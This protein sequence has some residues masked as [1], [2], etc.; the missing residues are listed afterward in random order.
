M[1]L[2]NYAYY[3]RCYVPYVSVLPRHTVF[4]DI[5]DFLYNQ[6]MTPRLREEIPLLVTRPINQD[7]QIQQIRAVSEMRYIFVHQHASTQF[8]LMPSLSENQA[9][10]LL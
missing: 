9:P 1:N 4:Y 6:R 10:S 5:V 7:I 2:R 3:I 8:I